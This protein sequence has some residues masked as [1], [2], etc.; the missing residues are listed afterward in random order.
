MVARGRTNPEIARALYITEHTV[1]AHLAKIFGK[2]GLE[3]RVQLATYA[4]QQGIADP[5]TADASMRVDLSD[6]HPQ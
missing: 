6:L 5:S 4:T 3:N 1:K 2:L